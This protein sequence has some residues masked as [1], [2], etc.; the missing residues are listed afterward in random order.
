MIDSVTVEVLPWIDRID[1]WIEIP[2]I[3]ITQNVRK[4]KAVGP[5]TGT[6]P[7]QDNNLRSSVLR[8]IEVRSRI[9]LGFR[10]CM[11][12]F[13]VNSVCGKFAVDCLTQ[14]SLQF[15]LR[16]AIALLVPV[17]DN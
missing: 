2:P 4:S 12:I 11:A 14:A 1:R 9:L 7:V 13:R 15:M 8:T 6:T 16:N 10:Y 3:Q 17:I 5:G